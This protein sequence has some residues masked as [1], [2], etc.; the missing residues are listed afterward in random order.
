MKDS[1]EIIFDAITALE[2]EQPYPPTVK[3]IGA[4]A[5]YSDSTVW[6]YVER[7]AEEGRVTWVPGTARTIQTVKETA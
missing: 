3:E 1:I 4:K 7:L 5:G 2:N 6:K